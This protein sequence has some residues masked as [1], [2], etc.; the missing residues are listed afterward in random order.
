[1]GFVIS[2]IVG[3]AYFLYTFAMLHIRTT[4]L[5]SSFDLLANSP[6]QTSQ[7]DFDEVLRVAADTC[8]GQH[9]ANGADVDVGSLLL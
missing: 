9:L 7:D 8:F 2:K 5:F 3:E 6:L 1:M 4:N